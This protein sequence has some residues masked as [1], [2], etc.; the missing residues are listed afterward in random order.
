MLAALVLTIAASGFENVT[1]SSAAYVTR[2][3]VAVVLLVITAAQVSPHAKRLADMPGP[4]RLLIGS[5]W[6]MVGIA[7]FSYTWSVDPGE[8]ALQAGVLALLVGN[9]HVHVV[10]RWSDRRAV[11]AD[12]TTIFWV[13]A[14]TIVLSL[15]MGALVGGR[16]SGLYS[17]PNSLGIL[18]AFTVALGVAVRADRNARFRTVAGLAA[19]LSVVALAGSASRTAA[20]AIVAGLA[21][22]V[23]RRRTVPVIAVVATCFAGAA[24][25]LLYMSGGR[26]PLPSVVDRFSSTGGGSRFSSREEIW[27]FAITLWEREPLT[28]YGF[29][30][31]EYAFSQMQYLGGSTGGAAFNSY[32]QVLLELGYIGMVPLTGMVLA[33]IWAIARARSGIEGGLAALVIA[34][35][36]TGIT[37]SSLFGLGHPIAWVFWLVGAALA[38]SSARTRPRPQ[39]NEEQSASLVGSVRPSLSE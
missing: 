5:S 11:T 7:A 14:V 27:Q 3:V 2:Y 8:T 32:L 25:T 28:G 30:T 38:A 22:M 12:V 18:A 13:L 10:R 35:L 20:L 1:I 6:L 26:L 19:V 9:M 15:G 39:G 23:L 29:R 16:L 24:V 4:A 36:A 17:N 21:L 33:L 34:G 37:E 31:G